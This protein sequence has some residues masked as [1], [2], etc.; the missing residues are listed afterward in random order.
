MRGNLLSLNLRHCPKQ[1]YGMLCQSQAILLLFLCDNLS[2]VYHVL[3]ETVSFPL[4]ILKFI[5]T[6]ITSAHH[7]WNKQNKKT[8]VVLTR[9]RT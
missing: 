7:G 1:K 5:I 9:G 4:I 8:K 6:N 3:P 2:T